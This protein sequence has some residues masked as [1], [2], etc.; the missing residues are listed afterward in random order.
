PKAAGKNVVII[1]TIGKSAIIDRL[2]RKNKIDASAISGKWESFF[3]QV[4]RKPLPGVDS[5][6]VI[7]GSDKRGTIYGIYDLSEEIG[8]SPWYY[9][10]DVPVKHHDQL[11]VR[12]GKFV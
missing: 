4:V 12:A 9:W 7:C 8:V 3:L 11:Y 10:A 2:I 1:G 5:A 6:L